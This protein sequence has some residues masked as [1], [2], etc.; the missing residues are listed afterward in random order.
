MSL[1]IIQNQNSTWNRSNLLKKSNDFLLKISKK[2]VDDFKN[3]G[4]DFNHFEELNII[5]IS[6]KKDMSCYF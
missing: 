4:Y 6:E 3:K 1:Y 5:T 2:V